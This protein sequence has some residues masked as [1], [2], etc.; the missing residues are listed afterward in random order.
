[1]GIMYNI[2]L[3]CLDSK[4]KQLEVPSI[5]QKPAISQPNELLNNDIS[6]SSFT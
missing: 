6:N 1:M 2:I 4:N 5:E 3:I